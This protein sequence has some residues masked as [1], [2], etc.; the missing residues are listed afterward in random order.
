MY[1]IQENGGEKQKKTASKD[2]I[3][4]MPNKNAKSKILN[5]LQISNLICCLP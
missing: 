2:L 1:L 4:Y 5:D 3:T